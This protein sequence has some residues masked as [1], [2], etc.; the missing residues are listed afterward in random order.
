MDGFAVRG[1]AE[2]MGAR[3][4]WDYGE[5]FEGLGGNGELGRNVQGIS[6]LQCELG[7][8]GKKATDG[9]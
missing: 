8:A 3:W 1:L 7:L 6:E 5:G 4:V 2:E 9:K